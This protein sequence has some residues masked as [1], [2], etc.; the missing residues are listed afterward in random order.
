MVDS[1]HPEFRIEPV[2]QKALPIAQ[3]LHALQMLAYA[4]ESKLLGAIHFPPLACTVDDVR[5]SIEAFLAAFIGGNMVG[6]VSTRPDEECL[7]VNIASL[8]VRPQFHRQGI[9]RLLMAKVLA[10]HYGVGLTVQTGADNLP[11]LALYA[12][13]GFVEIQRWHV[14]QE[15][16]E[17]VKLHRLPSTAFVV[18]KECEAKLLTK[19]IATPG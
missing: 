14:G 11:A 1:M 17:L 8:V 15:P 6:A 9:G 7:G 10:E 13:L 19:P 3:Q 2:T 4:Q 18:S 5:N 16:L 12:Q